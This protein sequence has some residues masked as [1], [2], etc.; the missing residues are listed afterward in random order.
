NAWA[1]GPSAWAAVGTTGQPDNWN[2]CHDRALDA[3]L[4]RVGDTLDPAGRRTAAAGAEREW[5]GYGCTIPLF[6]WPDVREVSTRLRNFAPDPAAA[7]TWNA[8]DWWLAA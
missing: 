1:P 2:R 6:E 8:A 3:D 7:D 4:A 5:L